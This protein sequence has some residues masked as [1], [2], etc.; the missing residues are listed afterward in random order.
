MEFDSDP[1][2]IISHLFSE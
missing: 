2:K 1:A